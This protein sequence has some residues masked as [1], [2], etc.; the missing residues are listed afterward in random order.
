MFYLSLFFS[1]VGDKEILDTSY[2]KQEEF[3]IFP[4]S[5]C[6][7]NGGDI[8]C[9]F[10]LANQYNENVR[11]W[12]NFGKVSVI[13][14][15]TIWCPYCREAA[16]LGKD[17]HDEYGEDFFW[18]TIL[19]EDNNGDEPD[20]YDVQF[21]AGLYELPH[22][23]LQGSRELIDGEGISGFPITGFPVFVILDRNFRIRHFQQG[24]NEYSVR[25]SVQELFLE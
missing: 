19:L 16:P 10:N 6:S 1:C 8:I 2:E 18:S 15:S 12:D 4:P 3:K 22:S 13:D 20:I 11:L 25:S 9:D 23:V 5:D 7:F 24:W 21:W 17:L 14:I